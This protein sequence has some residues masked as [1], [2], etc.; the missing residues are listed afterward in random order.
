M[1]VHIDDKV[2]QFP[3]LQRFIPRTD[4]ATNRTGDIL[5]VQVEDTF[6]LWCAWQFSKRLDM[7]KEINR[8]Y[9]LTD[10]HSY[11]VGFFRYD[12]FNTHVGWRGDLVGH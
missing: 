7:L 10:S 5:V 3:N 1:Q 9:E 6:E 8:Y 11:V 12:S 4:K 2:H